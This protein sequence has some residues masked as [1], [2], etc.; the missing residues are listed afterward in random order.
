MTIHI[1]YRWLVSLFLMCS[2]AQ[3]QTPKASSLFSGSSQSL[4]P[5]VTTPRVRA[6]LMVYAPDGVQVGKPLWLGLQLQHQVGW[7]SYWKNPGD[8]GLPTQLTWTLPAGVTAGN[9]QWP[10]PKKIPIAQLANY[11]YEGTVLLPVPMVVSGGFQA[12]GADITVSLKAQW[13]VC[14]TECVPEEGEFTLKLPVRGSTAL[15]RPLFDSAQSNLPKAHAGKATFVPQQNRMTLAISGLPASWQG[16]QLEAFPE[17][18]EIIETAAKLDQLWA[19]GQWTAAMPLSAQRAAGPPRL[20]WLVKIAGGQNNPAVRVEANLDGA[21]STAPA[22]SPIPVSPALNAAL[23][24]NKIATPVG[25]A[26]LV[27][28]SWMSAAYWLAI[29]GAILGGLVLNL[30]PCVLP[31]LAIKLLSFAPK[32]VLDAKS[33]VAVVKLDAAGS[34]IVQSDDTLSFRS[35]SG[36]FAVGVVGS[37]VLLGAVLLALRGAGQSFGWGFQLQSPSMVVALATLFLLIGLNLF[38][39]FDVQLLLPAGLINFQSKNPSIEA[40]ASGAL[41]VL[42]ATP[43]TAPFMGASLGLAITLPTLQAV[44]IFASLGLGMALPFILMA[45]FPSIGTWLLQ[46]LPKPG[47]WMQVM[48][49]LLAW[50]VFATVVWLLWVYAQQTSIHSLFAVMLSFLIGMALIWSLHLKRGGLRTVIASVFGVSL[51]ASFLLWHSA[52]EMANDAASPA[53]Q[54]PPL[55]GQAWQDWSAQKQSDAQTAGRPVLIDFTAAWCITCQINKSTTLNS[56]EI[57]A[58]FK[59]KNVLLLRADWTAPDAAIAA[60]LARLGRSGLPV[61]AFYLPGAASPQLLP[62][63]LTKTI[64]LDA[65][66]VL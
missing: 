65:L 14:K 24:K 1:F 9:I 18:S 37:F 19:N 45:L 48:R 21:W 12:V 59:A 42:I 27:V 58:A 29:L 25:E 50:P 5:V 64:I 56:A 54:N 3:A 55:N 49:H 16:K 41:A 8:S 31:V 10:T 13:L 15:S 2:F 51:L 44:L 52:A 11:G 36:L 20:A 46:V 35:S 60:E 6:E 47:A 43:C 62:E 30:M 57:Q 53:A 22:A 26:T 7:H 61:Y 4:S 38:D 17:T 23:A 39:A 33:S 28:A 66:A 34:A 40:L 63:V 32:K